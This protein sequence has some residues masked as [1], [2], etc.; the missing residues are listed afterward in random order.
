[1]EHHILMYICCHEL[2]NSKS[3]IVMAD[4][5]SIQSHVGSTHGQPTAIEVSRRARELCPLLRSLAS[6]SSLPT[7]F[8]TPFRIVLSY[9]G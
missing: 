4:K 7:T 9:L 2:A 8:I 5:F 3:S 6:G 1:M